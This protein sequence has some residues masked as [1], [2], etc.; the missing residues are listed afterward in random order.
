MA[1]ANL[2][3]FF[4]IVIGSG[5]MS[6]PHTTTNTFVGGPSRVMQTV[7]SQLPPPTLTSQVVPLVTHGGSMPSTHTIPIGIHGGSGPTTYTT[8]LVTHGGNGPSTY[9]TPLVT[10]GG[11]GPSIHTIYNGTT[12]TPNYAGTLCTY[13]P[14]H[15]TFPISHQPRVKSAFH[16]LSQLA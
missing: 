9:T 13:K 10:H 5:P 3:P 2:D 11:S 14:H 6:T 1:G 4:G 12:S 8:P 7:I 15:H 16:G